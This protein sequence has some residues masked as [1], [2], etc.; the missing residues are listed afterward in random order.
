M[1]HK[2]TRKQWQRRRAKA[3]VEVHYNAYWYL[4]RL[5]RLLKMKDLA[6]SF[7]KRRAYGELYVNG[8]YVKDLYIVRNEIVV[9]KTPSGRVPLASEIQDPPPV[10]P[11]TP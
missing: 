6:Y 1:N 5:L 4:F 7:F 3:R 2:L 11:R 9:R 10:T 8:R